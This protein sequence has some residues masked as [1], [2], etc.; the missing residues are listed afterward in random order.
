MGPLEW[1]VVVG[2][3]AC[4]AVFGFVVV[5]LTNILMYV[6]RKRRTGG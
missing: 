5:V 1:D 6:I 2:I 4:S 3:F